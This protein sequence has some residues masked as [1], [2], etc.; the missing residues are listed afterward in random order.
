MSRTA[1][2]FLN[3]HS[4]VV[5]GTPT[6]EP[7]DPSEVAD[8]VRAGSDPAMISMIADYLLVSREWVENEVKTSL[9]QR[10]LTLYLDEF[11]CWEIEVRFPPLQSVT[12]IVYLDT[13]GSSQTLSASLYR[14]DTTGK[15]GRI[16][17]AYGEIWPNAQCVTRA[18][19]VTATVGYT[20]AEL[21]P[22]CAKQ[23]MRILTKIML[24]NGGIIC[25]DGLDSVRRILD[26]IRWGGYA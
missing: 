6:F 14:V 15:P 13:D 26:P 2:S 9:G 16:T 7:L 4:E 24:D 19:T 21:V 22:A 25:E 8:H 3:L 20:S 5:K 17:P 11:P 1:E 10:T 23:A 12:S 18:V